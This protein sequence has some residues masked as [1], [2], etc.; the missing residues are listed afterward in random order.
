MLNEFHI[1]EEWRRFQGSSLLRFDIFSLHHDLC[2]AMVKLCG[3]N[4]THNTKLVVVLI[5]GPSISSTFSFVFTCC[6]ISFLLLPFFILISP[7]HWSWLFVTAIRN[8]VPCTRNCNI[9]LH[10][11]RFISPIAQMFDSRENRRSSFE[12]H[13]MKMKHTV[14]DERFRMRVRNLFKY[15]YIHYS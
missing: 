6:S 9:Y 14:K 11:Q 2:S 3:S 5:F 8:H 4:A 15:V 10:P 13:G 12:V 1:P 7:G